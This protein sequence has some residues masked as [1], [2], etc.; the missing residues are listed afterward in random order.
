M[1]G[2]L[3]SGFQTPLSGSKK[4]ASLTSV[5]SP[6]RRKRGAKGIVCEQIDQ[7]PAHEPFLR[8]VLEC[9]L[10]SRAD[11]VFMLAQMSARL[12]VCSSVKP[13]V[14]L[15]VGFGST[16]LVGLPIVNVPGSM[17][18]RLVSAGAGTDTAR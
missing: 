2:L 1:Q 13:P 12:G 9:R 14:V 4:T 17:N 16:S 7:N 18:T 5:A 11:P 6:V 10:Q 8:L 15:A 3:G